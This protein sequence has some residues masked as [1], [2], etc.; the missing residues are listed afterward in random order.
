MQFAVRFLRDVCPSL[1]KQQPFPH[2][3]YTEN[4][5][6]YQD[7]LGTNAGQLTTGDDERLVM[8]MMDVRTK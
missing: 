7:R 5:S 8:M 6:I 3:L 1:A 2:H 4:A